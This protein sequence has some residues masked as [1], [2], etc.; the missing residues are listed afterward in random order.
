MENERAIPYVVRMSDGNI[1]KLEYHDSLPSA[2]ALAREY[3]NAGYPDRY[4]VLAEEETAPQGSRGI[5]MSLILRPSVFPSQAVFI[6]PAAAVATALALREHTT[7]KIGI[8][9]VSNLFCDGELMGEISVEGK[10]DN[11]TSYEY[12]LIN[13]RLS[14]DPKKF[15][16]RLTDMIKKVFESE[17]TSISMII[18]KNILGRLF[19][20]YTS[21]KTP[22]RTMNLYKNLFALRGE[23]VRLTR[24][25]AS[26]SYKVLGIDSA[27]CA[28]IVESR[29]GTVEKVTSPRD[30]TSPRRLKKKKAT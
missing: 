2:S 10:L 27:T 18:A 3:A 15:P 28:L 20:L 4:V 17:N 30:L 8:G 19:P 9:W 22:Q 24:D 23:S 1:I 14:L 11:F 7:S 6:G 26:R 21:I 29:E 12:M 16:P 25:G 13:F 5:Y